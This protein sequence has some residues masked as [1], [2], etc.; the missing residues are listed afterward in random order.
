M[1]SLK[2]NFF[3]IF[4][5]KTIYAACLWGMLVVF[6]KLGNAQIVGQVALASAILTPIIMITNM[7]LRAVQAT[8]TRNEFFLSDYMAV[9]LIS[10]AIALFIVLL[11]ISFAHFGRM[12]FLTIV[13]LALIKSVES[14]SD[15]FYGFFQQHEQM[16]F[17]GKSMMIKGVFS[18]TVLAVVF[19][20]S[21]NLCLS[22]FGFLCAG[23]LV[24]VFYD[25]QKGRCLLKTINEPGSISLIR[26][27]IFSFIKRQ[28][29]LRG[30]INLSFPLGIVVGLIS[31]NTNIP[32]Y[33]IAKYF[34]TRDLGIFA[35]L[36]YTTVAVNM[37]IQALGQ[38][39]APRMARYFS[40]QK[41]LSFKKVL[42]K[43]VLFN[44]AIG[45]LG[46]LIIL[47]GGE[48]IL[49]IIYTPEYAAYLHLFSVLLIAA[50]LSGVAV[51]FGY[52]MTAARQFRLQVPLYL[53]VLATT[54]LMSLILIP[55]FKLYGAA[56]ALIVSALI[57]IAGGV[58][59]LKRALRSN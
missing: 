31:L 35:V 32:N 50:A 51:A 8:D 33:V 58:L 53:T 11:I 27:T 57:H 16:S 9:R 45:L 14:L 46:V 24:L 3:W 48:K 49:A 13:M 55:R 36:A 59:I 15:V 40:E 42:K 34:G 21:A 7:Q 28:K 17:V 52:A 18:L 10:T 12:M 29:I 41:I 25:W 38:A 23:I 1:I 26:Q 30:I 5:G 6:V 56:V 54:F 47:I 44:L 4:M 19:Y 39:V 43:M 2:V 22:L 20:F 37:L